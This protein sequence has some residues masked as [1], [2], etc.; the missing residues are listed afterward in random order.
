MCLLVLTCAASSLVRIMP[1]MT[2]K[3]NG[4]GGCV[5]GV[6]RYIN[7]TWRE[8]WSV[9]LR[10]SY[11]SQHTIMHRTITNWNR[12][13]F[14]AFFSL[15]RVLIYLN[16][17]PF[18]RL[19]RATLTH[20]HIY[21]LFFIFPFDF[22]LFWRTASRWISSPLSFLAL[23]LVL[24][25]GVRR[26]TDPLRMSHDNLG[27]TSSTVSDTL[28][29]IFTSLSLLPLTFRLLVECFNNNNVLQRCPWY[30]DHFFLF[31]FFFPFREGISYYL[32]YVDMEREE[33]LE[34][35]RAGLAL[36]LRTII[37]IFL[38]F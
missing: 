14:F 27:F 2:S 34:I 24:F 26:R 21:I 36:S 12:L 19:H 33:L 23:S 7:N 16:L 37:V 8:P 10:R 6:W 18:R 5:C 31:F 29:L 32:N 13:S 17:V 22:I 15:L 30:V 28:L 11:L 20:T 38:E 9:E 25:P 4:N 35:D 3:W 1:W